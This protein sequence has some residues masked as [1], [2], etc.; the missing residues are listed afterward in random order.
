MHFID[1]Y[2]RDEQVIIDIC[3]NAFL[4][5]MVRNI[6]GVLMEIGMG[7]Q[8]ENWTQHLLHIKNRAQAGVTAP[9]H[10]LH[11]GAV[12]YPEYYAIRKHSVFDKLPKDVRRFD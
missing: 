10:G 8:P 1:V 6:T 12:Y 2:R 4:H 5:H 3:A 7:R 11:L 9:P